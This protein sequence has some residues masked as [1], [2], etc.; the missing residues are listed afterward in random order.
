MT[1]WRAANTSGRLTA[2]AHHQPSASRAK[3]P[4]ETEFYLPDE[5]EKDFAA[6][7]FALLGLTCPFA[8]AGFFLT[9]WLMFF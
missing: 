3:T 9:V 7:C 5:S 8:L 2:G 1:H 6:L 4:R